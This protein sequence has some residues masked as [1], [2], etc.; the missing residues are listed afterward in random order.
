MSEVIVVVAT[1]KEGR[2]AETEAVLRKCIEATHA[3]DGCERYTLHRV[4]GE[5]QKFVMVEVWRSQSDIEAHFAS[6]HVAEM[7]SSLSD[8][9]DGPATVLICEP[10][11]AGD[12]VKGAL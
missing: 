8:V 6:P 9:A 1:M 3:E 11:A 5:P 10:V 12:A 4:K 7:M 2:E